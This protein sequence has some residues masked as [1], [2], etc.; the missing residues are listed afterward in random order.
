MCFPDEIYMNIIIFCNF[1]T[2]CNFRATCQKYLNLI[3]VNFDSIV[4]NQNILSTELY[5][6]IDLWRRNYHYLQ[7]RVTEPYR[8][9]FPMSIHSLTDLKAIYSLYRS[10]KEKECIVCKQALFL[11]FCVVWGNY[12]SVI[13]GNMRVARFYCQ[14]CYLRGIVAFHKIYCYWPI[15]TT[16][17]EELHNIALLHGN[18]DIPDFNCIQGL[19][20]ILHN[21]LHQ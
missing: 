15:S 19:D 1:R 10:E 8:A 4:S 14:S 12:I 18:D 9:P 2:A 11:R 3:E 16:D 17:R 13:N 5:T 7:A 6:L 20:Q 21:A